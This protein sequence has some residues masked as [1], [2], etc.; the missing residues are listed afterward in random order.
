M[1]TVLK[2]GGVLVCIYVLFVFLLMV[3]QRKMIYYPSTGTQENLLREAQA[4]KMAPWKDAGDDVIG[5]ISPTS[6]NDSGGSAVV[7][8]HGN[9]GYALQ[10]D[11]FV[12][13]FL[14]QKSGAP[15]TVYLFEYPGY[16]ARNGSPSEKSFKNRAAE[17]ITPLLEK[18]EKLFL[19]GESLGT[20]VAAFLANRFGAQID[21]LLLV[22]PFTKLADVGRKHYPIFP[23]ALLLRER[24]DNLQSLAGYNGPVAFLIAGSDEIIPPSLGRAL[25][26][27]YSGPKRIWVQEG[28]GHNTLNFAPDSTWWRE[29]IEFWQRSGETP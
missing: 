12:D 20:G 25:Y 26:E 9:A 15:W 16:G 22:T 28:R 29:V 23:V 19:V 14:S 21:G 6:G 2:I 8:F 10:R 18:H 3:S 27:A 17:A 1:I 11:Y 5:W 13:G 4:K 24:Y 7:I